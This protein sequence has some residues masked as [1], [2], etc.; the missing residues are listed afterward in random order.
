MCQVAEQQGRYLAAL[1]NKQAKADPGWQPTEQFVY[2]SMG[3]MA[4]V[5]GNAAVLE[6]TVG[7]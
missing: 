4:S 1:L 5:G 3:A 6:L 7:R 2:R